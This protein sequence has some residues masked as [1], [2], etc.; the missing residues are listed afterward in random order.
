MVFVSYS[1]LAL[2]ACDVD[3]STYFALHCEVARWLSLEIYRVA[4][5]VV[6]AVKVRY[7]SY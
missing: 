1:F 5:S 6:C 7:I 3:A 4:E 2:E